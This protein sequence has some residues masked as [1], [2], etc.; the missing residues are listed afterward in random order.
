MDFIFIKTRNVKILKNMT[1]IP[2]I[3]NNIMN[4]SNFTTTEKN[5]LE[6]E[7]NKAIKDSFW[8]A[9]KMRRINIHSEIMQCLKD[10][11]R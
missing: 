5:V 8:C 1:N 4:T 11:N 3:E 7:Y 6:L 9:R 2:S 10:Y